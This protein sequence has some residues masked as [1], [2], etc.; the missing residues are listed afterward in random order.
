MMGSSILLEGVCEE[1][2]SLDEAA[3]MYGP[4]IMEL[5]N[6]DPSGSK[7]RELYQ[8]LMIVN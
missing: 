8:E 7:Y 5:L 3:G 6:D 2:F 4:L 1:K